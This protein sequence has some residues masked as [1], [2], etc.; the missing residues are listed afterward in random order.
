MSVSKEKFN[1]VLEQGV[2]GDQSG[3]NKLWNVLLSYI[4]IPIVPLITEL[5][6]TACLG[7]TIGFTYSAKERSSS[8]KQEP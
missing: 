3:I 4:L 2:A 1:T 5:T 8:L 6:E 7:S